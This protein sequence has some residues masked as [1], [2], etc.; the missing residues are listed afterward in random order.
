MTSPRATLH[1]AVTHA[2][3]AFVDEG[4]ASPEADA[5][6]LAAF[7]LGSDAADVRRRMVLRDPVDPRFLDTYD[8]LVGERLA[9]VPL[10]HLTGRAFFRR[11]TLAVG[12]GVFVPRPETE[13]AAGLAVEAAVAAGEAPLV[14]DL[15]TGSGAIA[16][17]VKD[18][19]PAARVHAVE[20][21]DLAHGWA[22]ANRDR[23]GLDV[24]IRLGDARTAF[25]DLAGEVDVVVSNPPYIPDGAVPVDPEVRDHD[26]EVALYGRSADGLAVPLAVAARAAVL[27]RPGGVL[28]ME[29]ADTQGSTLPAALEAAGGWTDVRDH[30]DLAGRP[31]ATTAVRTT[32]TD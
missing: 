13:V 16:L 28:V 1:A 8:A 23:L 30:E 12:P 3:A 4:I 18:E 20:L 14:V 32:R 19:V 25:A 27:L 24:E 7:A 26:P 2:R 15:C 17:A 10:Q 6:E 21:S 29:H 11:L 22:V 9:R 5:V 31:R